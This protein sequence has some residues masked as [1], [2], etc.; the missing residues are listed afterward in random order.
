MLNQPRVNSQQQQR[1]R[2]FIKQFGLCSTLPFFQSVAQLAAQ[3]PT[4]PKRLVCIGT[5][6][7]MHAPAFFPSTTGPDYTL[8]ELLVP[9]QP[10]RNALTVIEGLDH[11]LGGGH[12]G[13][14]GFLTGERFSFSNSSMYS[15]DQYA[16]DRVGN[17]T[18]FPSLTLDLNGS[19]SW[20]W[21]RYGVKMRGI[22]NPAQL[23]DML[24]QPLL[25]NE[26]QSAT[27]EINVENSV[28]DTIARSAKQL[29]NKLGSQDRHKFQEYLNAVEETGRRLDR[30]RHWIRQDKP[31]VQDAKN[32]LHQPSS[33]EDRR[34]IAMRSMFD[35]CALAFRT[36]STRIVTIHIPGGNGVLKLDGIS[37][38]YHSLSHHGQDP[39][40]ILQLKRVEL[41]YVK[42]L[43]RFLN[44]LKDI[45]DGDGS[46]L[47]HTL[48]YFGSGMGN[49]SSHSNRNLPVL[50]AGGNMKHGNSLKY[51]RDT[52]PLC[53]LYVS[54]L[55][56]LGVE[57][58]SFG[59]SSGNMSELF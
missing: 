25:P 36:D 56:W 17:D 42:E 11:Q 40:K 35:L 58:D 57:T 41:Q 10:T 20:S 8:P 13:V 4:P 23:F 5:E 15:L 7:G 50:L 45:P 16:A 52:K 3:S 24:F 29:D 22:G 47:D 33:G 14:Q 46:M 43:A 2:Q 34:Y 37:D 44:T 39:E 1:R 28:L 19:N 30:S 27:A 31:A 9:L 54:M 49:A 51:Q 18:R 12:K 59:S 26:K 32:A 55:Q 21:N 6:Y 48:I 38:G 53:N